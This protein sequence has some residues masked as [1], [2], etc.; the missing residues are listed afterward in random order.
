MSAE[1]V[2]GG[3][4]DN[5]KRWEAVPN[6]NGGGGARGGNRRSPVAIKTTGGRCELVA[7]SHCWRSVG[8]ITSTSDKF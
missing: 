8:P 6:G 2:Q 5:V 1:G 3:G 7:E 4:G